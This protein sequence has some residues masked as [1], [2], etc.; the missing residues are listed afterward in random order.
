M[1]TIRK[2]GGHPPNISLM[3]SESLSLR[4]QYYHQ[5]NACTSL[6]FTWIL[7]QVKWFCSTGTGREQEQQVRKRFWSIFLFSSFFILLLVISVTDKLKPRLSY[8][9]PHSSTWGNVCFTKG[10]HICHIQ[11]LTQMM[12]M[13]GMTIVAACRS[14]LTSYPLWWRWQS[15]SWW[16][17]W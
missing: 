11:G 15:W 3:I 4:L 13:K 2:L 7:F 9:P 10:S 14:W 8:F 6:E 16:Y 12:I 1:K 17:Q 5:C